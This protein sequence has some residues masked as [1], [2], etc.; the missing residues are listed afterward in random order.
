MEALNGIVMRIVGVTSE[1]ADTLDG[2]RHWRDACAA[3][4]LQGSLQ[5]VYH[6]AK[7]GRSGIIA[8]K[9]TSREAWNM[10]GDPADRR[11]CRSNAG[12]VPE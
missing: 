4:S 3:Q 11:W 12:R 10:E 5:E 7:P 6:Y 8:E 2:N 9:P 1:E